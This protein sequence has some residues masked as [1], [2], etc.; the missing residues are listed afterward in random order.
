MYLGGGKVRGGG[1][2][3]LRRSGS[4]LRQRV[5]AAGRGSFAELAVRPGRHEVACG[6]QARAPTGICADAGAASYVSQ[7]RACGVGARA[8]KRAC[9]HKTALQQAPLS[10]ESSGERG[11]AALEESTLGGAANMA[12]PSREIASSSIG[13][14]AENFA[15]RQTAGE[16]FTYQDSILLDSEEEG[17]IV[18]VLGVGG[19]GIKQL[20]G[21]GSGVKGSRFLQWMP[22]VVSPVVHRV[23]EWEVANQSVFRAG[24]QIEF[25]DDQG[26][27]LRGTISGVTREDGSASFAQV[28]LDF[29]QQESR[30]YLPRCDV[31]HVHEGHGM[32]SAHQWLGRPAGFRVP[33]EVRAPPVHHFDERAQS[34]A[35]RPTTREAPFQEM[36]SADPILNITQSIPSSRSAISGL[37]TQE[38]ELDYEDEVP[39]LGAQALAA[40]KTTTSGLAVQGDRLSCRRDLAGNLRRGEVSRETSFGASGGDSIMAGTIKKM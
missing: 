8:F 23:Q 16:N 39:V 36:G 28:R 2:R 40:W 24:E 37:V 34:G 35:V 17:E 38:E 14:C 32:A 11:D 4:S 30:A 27:V 5:A 10:L 3:L 15:V 19:S 31:A 6:V 9:A 13:T 12:A 29:W 26:S 22:R 20:S 7:K 18:E 21:A 1:A 33:M 25:V